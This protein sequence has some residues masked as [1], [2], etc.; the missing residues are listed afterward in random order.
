MKTVQRMLLR[1]QNLVKY[2]ESN[3][4]LFS[5]KNDDEKKKMMCINT[6]RNKNNNNT[7]K[8]Q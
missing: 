2:Q 7:K 1:S 3:P 5:S 8:C 6:T 4:S